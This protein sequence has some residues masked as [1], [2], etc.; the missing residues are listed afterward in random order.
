MNDN[1]KSKTI[2]MDSE[3]AKKSTL[4]NKSKPSNYSSQ[5]ETIFISPRVKEFEKNKGKPK[6]LFNKLPEG[7]NVTGPVQM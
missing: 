5:K 7:F 3:S 6:L 2:E 1:Y 4:F